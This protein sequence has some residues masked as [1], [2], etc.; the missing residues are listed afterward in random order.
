MHRCQLISTSAFITKEQELKALDNC[1]K[2]ELEAEFKRIP[3]RFLQ[4]WAGTPQERKEQLEDAAKSDATI[5]WNC[6]GESGLIQFL[7]T[8]NFRRL[9]GK[10]IIG[11]S[12]C[13]LLINKA[14]EK[15]KQV[16]I[17]GPNAS[18][19]IDLNS[20]AMLKQLIDG[21]P[22][23]GSFHILQRTDKEKIKGIIK[24][25][26]LISLTWGIGLKQEVKLSKCIVVFDKLGK[27]NYSTYNNLVQLKNTG[28]FRPKAIVLARIRTQKRK[29]LFEMLKEL[30]P[31]IPIIHDL[32]FDNITAKKLSFPIGG[33]CE[34]N[35]KTRR[36]SFL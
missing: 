29:Q 7:N 15:T 18:T 10:S 22:L 23:K 33:R 2:L 5:L 9:K 11:S 4:K 36:I 21:K 16:M 30:F 6:F 27:D 19:T 8:I 13:T 20:A 26:N 24:G 3:R 35:L 12:D 14:Y 1:R 31:E 32:Q 25:G 34:I 17:H 28:S